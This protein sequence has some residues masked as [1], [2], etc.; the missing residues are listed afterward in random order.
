MMPLGRLL[1]PASVAV[2][3]G[4]YAEPAIRQL[5]KIGY[6]G[7]IHAVSPTRREIAGIA[8]VARVEDLPAGIDAAFLAVPAAACPEMVA[9]LRGR[10][11]GGIVCF[12]SEFAETGDQALQTALVEAAGDMPVLGPNCHGLINGLDQVAL[13]P[14][15][16]GVQP[17]DRGV[18]I[19]S[20]SGNIAITFTMQ[21]RSVPIG[22]VVSLG[23]QAQLGAS[24]FLDHLVLDPRVSAIGLH[25]EGLDD[26][27]AFSRSALAGRSAGKPIVVLK[28]GKS[29]AGQRA[30]VT[31]TSTLSGSREVY[32]AMFHRLG[33][34]SVDTISEFL[35]TLKL[36]HVHGHL[37]GRRICS[38]SC[39]GGEAALVADL[40]DH[41]GLEM[42]ALTPGRAAAV[43]A[44]LDGR[45][46]ADNPMD[47]Q[48]FIWGDPVRLQSMFS[49]YLVEKF[50]ASL[51]VLDYPIGNDPDLSSWDIT[52]DSWI[53]AST[54]SVSRSIVVATLPECFPADRRKR[55]MDAGIAPL[56]GIGEAMAAV[57]AASFPVPVAR[58][59]E[60]ILQG[61]G[62]PVLVSEFEA[63]GMLNA[64][65]L[66]VPG[67]CSV[68][69]QDA[70]DAAEAIGFPIVL[71]TGNPAIEHKTDAA[72]VVLGLRNAAE[73]RR[74]AIGL[75]RLGEHVLVEQ[76]MMDAVA[77]VIV[78]V[79]PE[80]GFGLVLVIGAGGIMA[81]ILD[82]SRTL[83][84]PVDREAVEEAILG[85]RIAKLLNGFRGRPAGDLPALV[86]AVMAIAI[87]A[88]AH[89]SRLM[90]LDVN[91]I[92]VLPVGRGVVAVDVL[93][94]MS[95][96]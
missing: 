92:L 40:A 25:L 84:F 75:S 63:K 30:T 31:H 45:V 6:R 9:V 28:T 48:T 67:G 64:F 73:V 52:L 29:V 19:L 56:Q 51:L 82:D 88:Q 18:A 60:V 69:W 53:A 8:T 49:A 72:G 68:P 96:E 4:R 2:I 86:D 59:I 77:E 78:G 16:H 90:E 37:P 80:Q 13:W 23:N 44:T 57:S 14:D 91:P 27:A 71:K 65:G 11:C 21:Q 81:E 83:L 62:T 66:P 94:R 41:H 20:Q 39:S 22:L 7:A 50:D 85:L 34:A 46:K 24:A 26:P 55:L 58:P 54:W 89:R 35:E 70:A 74:A 42:P 93:M 3:A 38:L 95:E 43:T 33:I 79:V 76:M 61:T 15:E 87:F 5:C 10:G 1:A 36:L 32:D 47:Y 17:L 12:S